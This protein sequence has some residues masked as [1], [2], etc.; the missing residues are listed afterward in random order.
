MNLHDLQRIKP[1]YGTGRPSSTLTDEKWQEELSVRK[2]YITPCDK[3]H[4]RMGGRYSQDVKKW[5]DDTGIQ[6]YGATDWQ[7]YVAHINDILNV[8][9]SGKV[10][11][12]YYVYQILD[13]LKFHYNDLHAKYIDGYWEVWLEK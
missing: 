13:L 2:L 4:K 7:R 8:I 9:R 11:Y 5:N 3:K 1:R 6:Y 12:C 10:D